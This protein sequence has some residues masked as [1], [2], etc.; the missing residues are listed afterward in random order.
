M[1]IYDKKSLKGNSSPTYEDGGILANLWIKNLIYNIFF[2]FYNNIKFGGDRFRRRVWRVWWS[3][4]S[5][6]RNPR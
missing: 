4:S 2:M 3:R 6:V 5:Y 1:S